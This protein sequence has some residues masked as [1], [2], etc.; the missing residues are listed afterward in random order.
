[1]RFLIWA[2]FRRNIPSQSA[3]SKNELRNKPVTSEQYAFMAYSSALMVGAVRSSETSV[4]LYHVIRRHILEDN[5]LHD[6]CYEILKS[7]IY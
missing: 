7:I 5:I 4:K 6:H 3:G 1:M 2:T